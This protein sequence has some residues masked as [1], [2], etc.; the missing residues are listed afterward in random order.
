M[1]KAK[2]ERII[3]RYKKLKALRKKLKKDADDI[4]NF[5]NPRLKK[6]ILPICC[7][8]HKVYDVSKDNYGWHFRKNVFER[9]MFPL[10]VMSK[11]YIPKE[12]RLCFLGIHK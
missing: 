8:C 7:Y 4:R 9:C 1:E 12:K 2:R 10:Q 3:K 11:I 5:C 6:V